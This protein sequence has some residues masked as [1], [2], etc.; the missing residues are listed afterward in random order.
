MT[1][2]ESLGNNTLPYSINVNYQDTEILTLSSKSIDELEKILLDMKEHVTGILDAISK[3]GSQILLIL[4]LKEIAM[5]GDSSY[6]DLALICFNY[7]ISVNN[8]TFNR[9]YSTN[10]IVISND[11]FVTSTRS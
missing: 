2:K 10:R 5:T 8:L 3:Q 11:M 6:C 4:K 9:S 1:N 7:N